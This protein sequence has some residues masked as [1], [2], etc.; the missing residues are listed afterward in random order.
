MFVKA[1]K[2]DLDTKEISF[3]VLNLCAL[4]AIDSKY[5]FL[6]TFDGVGGNHVVQ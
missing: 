3:H 2:N 4:Y 6:D 1:L 5:E